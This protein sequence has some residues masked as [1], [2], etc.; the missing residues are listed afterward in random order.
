M[1]ATYDEADDD[2]VRAYR[3]VHANGEQT[4]VIIVKVADRDYA[5]IAYD[6]RPSDF[7]PM[8]AV[9]IAYD[10]TVEGVEER[11]ERWM[12]EHPKGAMQA[13]DAEEDSGSG[14]LSKLK[15]MAGKLNEYG[16]DLREQQMQQG[17]QPMN[18]DTNE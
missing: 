2:V 4:R 13:L 14:T 12:Q 15:G 18:E 5:A 8:A 9:P 6:L 10:P 17:N 7:T 3:R 16:N 11:A 1:V